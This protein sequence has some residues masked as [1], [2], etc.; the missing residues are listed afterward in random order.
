MYVIHLIV[1]LNILV[2]MIDNKRF[3]LCC[4]VLYCIRRKKMSYGDDNLILK[5]W[6]AGKFSKARNF[7]SGNIIY[8]EVERG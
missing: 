8:L 5:G 6:E 7:F 4:I 3:V 1:L 2:V